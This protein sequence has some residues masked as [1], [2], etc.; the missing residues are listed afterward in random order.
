MR[1][2]TSHSDTCEVLRGIGQAGGGAP[3]SNQLFLHLPPPP[4]PFR[5]SCIHCITH[6]MV[7]RQ[8]EARKCNSGNLERPDRRE[9]APERQA[10]DVRQLATA[11][12]FFHS[13][14]I[15]AIPMISPAI[16]ITQLLSFAG[17]FDGQFWL[18]L[19]ILCFFWS[20]EGGM[21]EL[22]GC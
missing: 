16:P 11:I 7:C 20:C 3:Q 4:H 12:V 22:W 10:H 19:A 9:I 8:S 5:S 13:G 15:S 17:I 6:A 1:Q 21:V 18:G 2:S 14:C